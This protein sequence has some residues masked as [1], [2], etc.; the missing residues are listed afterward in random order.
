[1]NSLVA[2]KSPDFSKLLEVYQR[3]VYPGML[4]DISHYLGV[5][6]DSFSRLGIGYAPFVRFE[7]EFGRG[8][9]WTFPERDAKGIVI[10]MSLRSHPGDDKCM[11]PGSKRGLIY[12]VNSE[13]TALDSSVVVEVK[14][15]G[16][17]CPICGSDHWCG[18]IGDDPND[19]QAVICMRNSD[20]A[21]K[22]TANGGWLHNLKPRRQSIPVLPQSILPVVVVEGATDTAAAMD[23]GFVA[24]GRPAANGGRQLLQELLRGRKVMIVA[25]NDRKPDGSWPGKIGAEATARTLRD[26]GCD[27]TVVFPPAIRKDLRA[28]FVLDQL[29]QDSFL[30]YVVDHAEPVPSESQII[31]SDGLTD[32][33]NAARFVRQ[34]R[35]TIRYTDAD[36]WMAFDGQ[37]WRR[38]SDVVAIQKA[39]ETTKALLKEA[40]QEPDAQR[41]MWFSK[42]ATQSQNRNKISAMIELAKPDLRIDKELF[43]AD[44]MLLNCLNGTIDLRTGEIRKHDREDY[45]TKIANT[46]F[47]P[48]APCPLWIKFLDRVFGGDQALI[49]YIQRIAGYWLTGDTSVQEIWVMWGDGG[50]GKSVLLDT[51][52]G[53]LGDYAMPAP[54]GLLVER[55]NQ[56]HPTELAALCGTRLVVASETEEGAKLRLQLIKRLTGDS[57]MTARHMRQDYFV[58]KRTFKVSLVTN[59]QPRVSENSEAAWR[60]IRLIPFNVVIPREERDEKLGDRLRAEWPGIL[61]WA[62]RGC[63]AWQRSGLGIPPAVA[64][65]T[66][67]YRQE[68]DSVGRFIQ[69]CC[70]PV[71]RA[72]VSVARLHGVYE[73]WASM[74]GEYFLPMRQFG[75]ALEKLGF[76]K[77]TDRTNR[78][79]W[80][81]L[82]LQPAWG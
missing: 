41:R 73:R 66:K 46:E 59:N 61:A 14:K 58:F 23:L 36:G 64:Q 5:S 24:V 13:Y 69:E 68:Q 32:V 56:E 47:H 12:A 35:A 74:R 45:Q 51:L 4:A 29:T 63:L 80:D 53:I 54:D 33:G 31:A 70:V 60:R 78:I 22:E 27:V 72:G 52:M 1:V 25:E 38:D 15:A 55:R 21:I 48:D 18:V 10:G 20:G 17:S 37:V 81:K 77:S 57:M 28:W 19:P 26:V 34:H 2:T 65:A 44:P 49:D 42:W 3:N 50:N 79:V 62:V 6:A 7:K 11:Y 39:V 43:D 16:I 67:E 71:E 40:A 8:G 76:S 9:Y 75:R 82:E 30:R